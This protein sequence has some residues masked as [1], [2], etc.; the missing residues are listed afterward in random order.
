MQNSLE[1]LSQNSFDFIEI[2]KKI[3]EERNSN[4]FV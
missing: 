2:N 4:P 1:G 3:K